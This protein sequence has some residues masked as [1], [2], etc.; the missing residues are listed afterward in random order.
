[1][2]WLGHLTLDY[3]RD[4]ER[5]TAHD[6]HDGP[7]RVLQR[8]YP[9]GP[10]VCHH[11]LVHPPG[12]I[13]GGD[14][15]NVQATL[16]EGTHA[17]ITT[18]GATRFY[19]S[20]GATAEQSLVARVADGAR[21]EW[22][23]LETIAYRGCKAV[24][25]MRF[26]LA[27]GAEMMGWDLLALGLP[28]A[29]EAFD[30]PDHAD[31]FFTQEIEL[32]GVWLERG[33]VKASDHRL[34]D[35]PLGWAGRRVSGTF[36][37]ATGSAMPNARRQQLLDLARTHIDALPADA[38]CVAGATSTHERAVVVRAL[39]ARVEPMMGLLAAIW[40]D[41]RQHGWQVTPCPPRVWKT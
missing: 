38:P 8:L 35:S 18:P 16:A 30:S 5:T 11:V 36:W 27:P 12:G 40:A 13:V 4:G 29:N 17:V 19:K 25:R 9:E 10:E 31:A 32:P 2:S 20:S 14:V 3:R 1:M 34:L 6:R 15:L 37:F 33:T 28:A 7:L 23:P 26:E 21:L 22:L 39:A 41:W 24:N